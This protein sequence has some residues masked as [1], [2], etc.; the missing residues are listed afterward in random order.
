M[1]VVGIAHACKTYWA[2]YSK[3]GYLHDQLVPDASPGTVQTPNCV[4]QRK[5]ESQWRIFL[6]VGIPAILDLVATGVGFIGFLYIPSSTYQMLRGSMIVFSAV[7]S[8]LLLGRRL[9]AFHWVG[10]TTCVVGIAMV[11]WS[12]SLSSRAAHQDSAGSEMQKEAALVVFGVAMVLLA[13][14]FQ[15]TQVIV[16]EQMLKG[17]SV[18][19]MLLVGYEGVWG[20]LVMLGCVLPALNYAPGQD[21]GSQENVGD[22]LVM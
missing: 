7:E 19:P 9:H 1:A 8:V 10:I 21:D 22:T 2:R 11:G 17:M 4:Q 3:R 12:N 18:A 6:F 20:S 13:Q 15:A 14:F 5:E 16:E